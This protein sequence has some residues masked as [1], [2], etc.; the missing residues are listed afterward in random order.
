MQR[1]VKVDINFSFTTGR[2]QS[3]WNRLGWTSEHRWGQHS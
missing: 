2:N 1:H 3:I